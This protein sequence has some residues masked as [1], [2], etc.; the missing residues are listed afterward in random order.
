MTTLNLSGSIHLKAARELGSAYWSMLAR[1][2]LALMKSI[3]REAHPALSEAKPPGAFLDSLHLM[4]KGLQE[5]GVRWREQQAF[6]KWLE[7]VDEEL[8]DLRG[9]TPMVR[10]QFADYP[11]IEYSR[12][13]G[14][15]WLERPDDVGEDGVW[16]YRL[17][18]KRCMRDKP[19]LVS[20]SLLRPCGGVIGRNFRPGRTMFI[21]AKEIYAQIAWE[22]AKDARAGRE[23]LE[24]AAKFIEATGLLITP[25]D[26]EPSPKDSMVA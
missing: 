1:K 5:K 15:S 23:I 9:F 18:R 8:A 17:P 4:A 25:K 13:W 16:Q 2:Q 20:M 11:I 26:T 6:Q 24:K 19:G 10:I 14:E 22:C 3:R 7:A 21:E 12:Y